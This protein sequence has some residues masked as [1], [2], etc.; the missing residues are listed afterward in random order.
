M[1]CQLYLENTRAKKDIIKNQI[2][3]AAE[4]YSLVAGLKLYYH[5]L[6]HRLIWGTQET[7]AS[8]GHFFSFLFFFGDGGVTGKIGGESR[9][10]Q[11]GGT[12]PV[13]AKN[14]LFGKIFSRKL[15]ENERNWTE[16]GGAHPYYPLDPSMKMM[17]G[18]PLYA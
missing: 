14:Q 13:W 17:G 10:S 15:H 1:S 5:F 8:L 18:N 3:S 12:N 4:N 7:G 2:S 9:I 11:T 16:R 6:F